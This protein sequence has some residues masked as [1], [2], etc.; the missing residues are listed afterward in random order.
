MHRIIHKT[1][2]GKL[3]FFNSNF[4]NKLFPP[5]HLHDPNNFYTR[6]VKRNIWFDDMKGEF[7][8]SYVN[9]GTIQ[10]INFI[11]TSDILLQ[12]DTNTIE[13]RFIF[14]FRNIPIKPFR[15]H[16]HKLTLNGDEVEL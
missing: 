16:Y 11:Y 1:V 3:F 15:S 12:N 7:I 14:G 2:F 10:K 8:F 6:S 13:E 4:Y 5:I 9:V